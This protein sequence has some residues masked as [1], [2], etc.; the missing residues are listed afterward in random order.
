[1][2]PGK[3]YTPEDLVDIAWRRKWL[4]VVPFVVV[5]IATAVVTQ[6][7]P[8]RKPRFTY[9]FSAAMDCSSSV[10]I[11]CPPLFCQSFTS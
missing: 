4:I 6:L 2:I 8:K 5:A 11:W 3:K 9:A 1:M 10:R 7:T